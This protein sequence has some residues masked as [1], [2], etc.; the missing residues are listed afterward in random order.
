M[1]IKPIGSIKPR[2]YGLPKL[3]KQQ[4]SFKTYSFDDQVSTAR[5]GQISEFFIR[6]RFNLLLS[7]CGKRLI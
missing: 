7:V 5:I 2:M 4:N 3:H 6:A 1:A